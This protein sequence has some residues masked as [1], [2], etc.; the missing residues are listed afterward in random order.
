MADVPDRLDV[1]TEPVGINMMQKVCPRGSPLHIK[2]RRFKPREGD[3]IH[4][5]WWDSEEWKTFTL[6]PY[7]LASVRATTGYL[8][9]Y[10]VKNASAAISEYLS[11]GRA[12]DMDVES[13]AHRIFHGHLR[14]HF[15]QALLQYQSK[16]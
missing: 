1:Y 16:V 3:Q 14:S 6:K 13:N 4:K 2:V 9:S 5:E 12:N 8:K 15:V 7:A 11:D 10:V